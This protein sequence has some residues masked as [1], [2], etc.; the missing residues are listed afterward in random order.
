MTQ[1][2]KEIV[3][4]LYGQGINP[5]EIA[6]ELGYDETEVMDYYNLFNEKSDED[7][8]HREA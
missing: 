8:G 3:A 7:A 2:Q 5:E 4:H 6:D 1:T